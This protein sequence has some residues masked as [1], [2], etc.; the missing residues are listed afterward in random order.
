MP[1]AVCLT[2]LV[3]QLRQELADQLQLQA[4]TTRLETSLSDEQR[5]VRG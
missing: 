5:K 3:R 4:V 2:V 1:A